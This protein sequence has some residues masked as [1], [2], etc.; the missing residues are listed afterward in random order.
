MSLLMQA[1][2]KA[3]R[4][5]QNHLHDDER[6]K[7]SEEL[8]QVLALAPAEPS[9]PATEPAGGADAGVSFTPELEFTPELDMAP[10]GM[11]PVEP[12]LEA[13]D[14]TPPG[15]PARHGAPAAPA[16]PGLEERIAPAYEARS[17]P[18]HMPQADAMPRAVPP[19]AGVRA[20]ATGAADAAY[21]KPVLS[22]AGAASVR[23]RPAWV[24][25]FTGANAGNLRLA[26]LGGAALLLAAGF[27]YFYW[28]AIHGAGP[29]ASLPMVPMPAQQISPAGS[30]GIAVAPSEP[31]R[32]AEV[33]GAAA[34]G[35]APVPAPAPAAALP[36]PGTATAGGAE[37]S[38]ANDP[39]QARGRLVNGGQPAPR[40]AEGNVSAQSAPARADHGDGAIRVR[41]SN[42]QPQ[43]DPALQR[44]Y[45]AFNTGDTAAARQHYGAVLRQDPNSRD[46]LLGMAAI[47]LRERQADAAA[48]HYQRLLELDPDDGE[49]LAG[50]I[51]LRQGDPLHSESRLKAQLQRTPD[52]AALQFALGNLYAQQSR[53]P[54]AQQAYFRAYGNSPANPDYA[55]NLAVGL[56]RL[57]QPKLAADYYRRA[58]ALAGA[59]P[60]GFDQAAVRLRLIEL[61]AGEAPAASVPSAP[62]AAPTAP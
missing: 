11:E 32:A 15:P 44:A 6:A 5:K 10:L 24:S 13:L 9:A 37:P 56:D 17:A 36:A 4:A 59:A 35:A 60:G 19:E 48:A 47:A 16:A 30:P 51:G 53:W 8:D 38:P 28:Q 27:G 49:A 33:P 40:A 22:G 18:L 50:L 1:L 14:Y 58:L 55:F 39:I 46:A 2:K 41:R 57:N 29:G 54:E 20:A 23:A 7:P 31:V 21:S 3:E 43:I 61:G 25:R 34:A 42:A 12:T 45:L 62:S 26:V 52:D